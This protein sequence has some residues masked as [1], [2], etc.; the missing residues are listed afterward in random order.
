MKINGMVIDP[1]GA[2]V[3]PDTI[4][5]SN[6]FQAGGTRTTCVIGNTV[7]VIAETTTAY[8]TDSYV[9]FLS[10]DPNT[11]IVTKTSEPKI[12]TAGVSIKSSTGIV[13]N[14][15]FIF[16]TAETSGAYMTIWATVYD[17]FGN[18][19]SRQAVS[20]STYDQTIAYRCDNYDDRIAIT[21]LD[22]DQTYKL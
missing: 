6:V 17:T 10:Y 2:I 8:P 22:S 18:Q 4:F 13:G 19:M 15:V 5:S 14:N 7:A 12:N 3:M 21:Y 9:L 1:N 11:G 20:G 16:F